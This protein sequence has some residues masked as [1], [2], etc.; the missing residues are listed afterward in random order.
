M[1]VTPLRPEAL[2]EALAD[3]VA[4]AAG[5][6]WHRVA[7]DGAPASRPGDLADALVGPLRLRGRPV[8]RVSASAFLRPASVRYERGREDPDG[9]YEDWL[10]R[11]ALT[12][13]VLLPLAPG[14]TGRI[15]MTLWDPATDRATRASYTQAAERAVLLVDGPLLL[16]RV[17]PIDLAVHVALSSPALERRTPPH[18]RWMLAAFARYTREVAP[19]VVADLVV[20]ADDAQRPALVEN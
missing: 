5:A 11:A 8:L 17:L 15:L 19:E 3:R 14:G 13:E 12:R 1:T 20:R 18:E 16:G 4:A 2:A 7:V 10:D 6:S 9:Y